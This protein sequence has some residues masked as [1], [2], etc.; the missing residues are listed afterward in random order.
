M[1]SKPL[2]NKKL[3]NW[4]SEQ[5]FR[6]FESYVNGDASKAEELYKDNILLSEALYPVLS[7]FEVTLRNAIH[8]ELEKYHG[9]EDWY[10][11][12]RFY[13][14]LR[15][16]LE[17]VEN[18]MAQIQDRQENI[19]PGK[20]IAEMTLGFWISLFNARYERILWKPLRLC[21]KQMPKNQ[22]QRH[23]VSSNLNKIRVLRNRVYHYE[24]IC[25]N[26][27]ALENNYQRIITTLG[28]IDKD[29]L[30]WIYDID[31][32]PNVLDDIKN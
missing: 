18:A 25:W 7:V 8:I 19:N 1:N 6:K 10:E 31:G 32:F 11:V 5:R 3:N 17:L 28:W 16:P 14:D 23:V 15:G 21:F 2:G 13:P 29:L 12:W 30:K 22:R 4:F 27:D 26:L 24:P 20:L 9:Q